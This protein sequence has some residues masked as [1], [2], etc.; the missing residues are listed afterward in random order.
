MT[1]ASVELNCA[2]CPKFATYR[3]RKEQSKSRRWDKGYTKTKS[4][5]S[6]EI[7]NPLNKKYEIPLQ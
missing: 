5:T 4:L 2:I 3:F 6:T 1:S 7:S